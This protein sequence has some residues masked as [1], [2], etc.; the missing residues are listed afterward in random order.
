MGECLYR[1]VWSEG[2]ELSFRLCGSA[3]GN[4]P[5]GQPGVE[6]LQFE[7]CERPFPRKKEIALGCAQHEDHQFRR[8]QPVRQTELP[9]GLEVI[10]KRAA[11]P[12]FVYI[13]VGLA[14]IFIEA[15]IQSLPQGNIGCPQ[16]A[17]SLCLATTEIIRRV[18]QS[19]HRF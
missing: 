8:S 19:L 6:K 7:G 12:F 10:K 3:D 13:S 18:V 5:D 16:V 17:F 4:D 1:R 11:R 9:S 15:E 2:V 14:T